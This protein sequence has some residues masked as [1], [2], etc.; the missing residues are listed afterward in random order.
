M[1]QDLRD[2]LLKAGLVD[3]KAKKRAFREFSRRYGVRTLPAAR[4]REQRDGSG[5]VRVFELLRG[6]K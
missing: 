6:T 1:K 5:Y 2:K 4:R 3:K